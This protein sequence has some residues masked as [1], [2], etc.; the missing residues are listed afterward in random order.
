MSRKLLDWYQYLA[1]A[2]LTPLSLWLWWQEYSGDLYLLSITWLLPILYAYIVPAIGTNVLKVWEFDTRLRLGRFRPHHGF[3]FGSATSMLAWFCHGDSA[4]GLIDVLGYAFILA[5]V[6]GFWNIVYDI[7]AIESGLLKVYNQ[8]WAEGK[9]AATI[10]M[11]Y[12]PW[13][14]AG[15]GIVFGAT[16]GLTEWWVNSG[17]INTPLFI[18][19]FTCALLLSMA[20]PVIGYRQ[21]SWRRHGHSG[22][23]PVEKKDLEREN[24]MGSA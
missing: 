24:E 21:Q 1:P 10:T 17:A 18:V 14:F 23:H 5:S 22:C 4:A 12:A 9:D 3:V 8:P 20:I 11:D 13:F 2:I 19:Y 15:F 7:R 6:L 16:I